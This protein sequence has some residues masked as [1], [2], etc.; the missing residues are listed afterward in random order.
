MIILYILC[1]CN[2]LRTLVV[3]LALQQVKEAS[4]SATKQDN[5]NTC[6]CTLQFYIILV[7]SITIIGLVNI[8][9]ITS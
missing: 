5:N 2:K 1:K 4:A 6:D 8:H 7:L 3:S 9:Y